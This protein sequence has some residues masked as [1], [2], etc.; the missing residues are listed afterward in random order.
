[1]PDV[2]PRLVGEEWQKWANLL[3]STHYGPSDYQQIP[4]NRDGDGGIEG[5]TRKDG[6]VFQ[7]YGCEPTTAAHRYQLQ[8]DKITTDIRKFIEN[9]DKLL[10][11]FGTTKITRWF[12]FVP[13]WDNKDLVSHANKKAKEVLSAN[14]PYVAPDFQ[15]GIQVEDQYREARQRL[16]QSYEDAIH[17]SCNQATLEQVEQWSG[18]HDEWVETLNDKLKKLPTLK[19][20]Q[21]VKTFREKILR[22]YIEGQE[23][24][25]N[26]R[27]YPDVYERII[28]TKRHREKCLVTEVLL[29]SGT[30]KELF[31]VALSKLHEDYIGRVKHLAK[32][33]SEALAYEAVGDWLLRCPLYFPD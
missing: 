4:D 8:R 30:P 33:N 22:W 12:L 9:K 3:L 19:T 27:N 1:M 13:E 21:H 26:L 11:L 17:I 16:L 32:I 5:F 15:A 28:E 31:E 25:N 6:Y 20:S 18:D 23:L 24:L 7:C 2:S 14:L 29:H 10:R